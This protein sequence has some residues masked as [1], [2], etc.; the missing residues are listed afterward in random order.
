MKQAYKGGSA[1][2]PEHKKSKYQ[3]ADPYELYGDD[4]PPTPDPNQ[5]PPGT[6]PKGGSLENIEE[7]PRPEKILVR[8]Y[9][10]DVK[11]GMTYQYRVQVRM[12][13][14]CY[15]KTDRA[16]SK[17]ITIDKEIR[18]AWAEMPEVVRVPDEMLFYAVDEKR[19][20]GYYYSDKVAMQVQ[21]WLE[22]IQTDPNNRA[23]TFLVG[24]WSILERD[25][26]RRGEY[27]GAVKETDVPVWWPT[28]KKF[29]FA[30]HPDDAKKRP[31]GSR[32]KPKGV[33]LNFDTRALLVDFEGGK[34]TFQA[35]DKKVS[36]ESQI[37][38][39]VLTKDGKLLV[40]DNKTDTED[41]TREDRLKQWKATLKE[42]REEVDNM[43]SAGGAPGSLGNLLQGKGK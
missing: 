4:T 20:E 8:F 26:V 39:L 3:D 37:E 29:L 28:A 36:D 17:N 27:I 1:P 32:A 24:D 7:T 22:T 21:E 25:L 34:Q 12:A 41:K 5:P 2:P 30:L 14:P 35:P 33:P 23:S 18:G 19:S 6:K 10:T 9:D 42:V 16:V 15:K 43:K 31:A 13:N 11:P 40:R 38:I